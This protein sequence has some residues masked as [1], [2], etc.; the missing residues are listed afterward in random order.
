MS[1]AAD[2]Q[3]PL[4]HRG[5][6]I[7]ALPAA[8]V[9]LMVTGG[10]AYFMYSL[11]IVGNK[12]LEDSS[13]RYSL[14]FVRV[15]HQEIIKRE[16]PKPKKP[17]PPKAPP[18]EP[19]TPKLSTST[20]TVRKIAIAPTPVKTDITLTAEGF[21]LEMG[22]S[23]EYLPIAKVAP[24]YPRRAARKGI[25]GHCTVQYT[26]K[27]DGSVYGVTVVEGECTHSSFKK[28]S[29]EA[30]KKF[31]YKP[32]VVDGVKIE[33]PGVRNRFTYELEKQR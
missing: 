25:E 31:K 32:R 27:T 14:D 19:P 22:S 26:V 10:L 3:D 7:R 28:P 18:P 12:Q 5:G 2:M 17:P 24:M 23:G 9:A 6:L 8:I 4:R 11:I 30:A 33:V 20:P 29:I 1:T 15:K 13:K 16:T 21:S